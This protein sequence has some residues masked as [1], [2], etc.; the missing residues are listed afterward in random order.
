MKRLIFLA[1]AVVL[2]IGVTK[3]AYAGSGTPYNDKGWRPYADVYVTWDGISAKGDWWVDKDLDGDVTDDN[4]GCNDCVGVD[5]DFLF[6]GKTL[7]FDEV[8][9]SGVD[10]HPQTHHVVL[11]DLD[12]DGVYKGSITARY[13][14][15]ASLA[16]PV[17][18]DV[19]EYTIDTNQLGSDNYFNY[20]E[21]EYCLPAD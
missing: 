8:Y 11:N 19:I 4:Y 2:M 9:V 7:Q 13:D 18:M 14:Y 20:I 6:K 21:N 16:C 3:V 15:D 12:N 17:R 1:I 10:A 5:Y